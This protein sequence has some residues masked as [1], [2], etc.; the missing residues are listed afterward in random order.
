[1]HA[2][3]RGAT[4]YSYRKQPIHVRIT[5]PGGGTTHCIVAGRDLSSSGASFLYRGFLHVGTEA[6]LI[7]NRRVGGEETVNG[8]VAWCK[9]IVG[10]HHLVAVR[11][12]Q[13]IYPKLFVEQATWLSDEDS[14]CHDPHQLEARVLQIADPQSDGALFEHYAKGTALTVVTVA[15]TAD[16]KAAMD[17][18][19]FDVVLCDVSLSPTPGEMIRQIRSAGFGGCIIALT[20]V[21]SAVGQKQVQDAG[22][23]FSVQ[24]PYDPQALMAIMAR[25]LPPTATLEPH[26]EL[27]YSDLAGASGAKALLAGYLEQVQQTRLEL[28]QAINTGNV[29]RA[30]RLCQTLKSNGSGFGFAGLADAARLAIK[31]LDAS[32]SVEESVGELQRLESVCVRLRAEPKPAA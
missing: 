24:K 5:Q 23:Q 14:A 10:P 9:H 29:A 30:R 32:M 25:S 18:Q 16:A 4:R 21:D 27:F 13:K 15:A 7:L 11:F 17:K 6:R 3:R 28:R 20:A 2:N 12:E 19:S 22:A 1:M 26:E 8:T 31:A